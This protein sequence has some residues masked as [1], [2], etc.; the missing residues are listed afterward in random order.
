M[1]EIIEILCSYL[2]ASR[3]VTRISPNDRVNPTGIVVV[4]ADGK[5]ESHTLKVSDRD[6]FMKLWKQAS[7]WLSI[8]WDDFDSN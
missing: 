3:R 8:H 1:N 2:A 6:E 4:L 7:S 5:E